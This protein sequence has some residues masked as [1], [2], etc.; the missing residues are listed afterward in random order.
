[1]PS[2]LLTVYAMLLAWSI[3]FLNKPLKPDV[4]A[5]LAFARLG[6]SCT[7]Y[8]IRPRPPICSWACC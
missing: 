5:A 2:N 1:M 4:M 3:T 6:W 8:P 7:S